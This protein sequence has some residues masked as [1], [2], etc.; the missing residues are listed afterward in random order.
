MDKRIVDDLAVSLG[1]PDHRRGLLKTAVAG[2]LAVAGFGIA[3]DNVLG[4]K[5][6]KNS[7]CPYGKKCRN[8]KRQNNGERKGRCK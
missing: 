7:D 5:C 1:A 8:K 6:E 3:A 4:K 2:T